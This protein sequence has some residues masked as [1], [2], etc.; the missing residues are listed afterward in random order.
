VEVSKKLILM[1]LSTTK[2]VSTSISV[3]EYIY[4]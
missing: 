2:D 1:A 3:E 4:P